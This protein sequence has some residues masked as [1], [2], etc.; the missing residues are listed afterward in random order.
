MRIIGTIDRNG[1]KITVFKMG[2][3]HAIKFEHGLCEQT[4][5]IREHPDLDSMTDLSGL[6]TDTFFKKVMDRFSSMQKDIS[7][8]VMNHFDSGPDEFEEII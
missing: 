7:E 1:C 3:K 6:I 8:T 5:K 2:N 4:Y